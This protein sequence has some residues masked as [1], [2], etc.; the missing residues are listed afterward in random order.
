MLNVYRFRSH[1]NR[2]HRELTPVK[3]EALMKA[4]ANE[5]TE[6]ERPSSEMPLFD[7]HDTSKSATEQLAETV[8]KVIKQELME[9]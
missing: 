3:M 5:T 1:L 9:P 7:E 8:E 6:N 4:A 2:V